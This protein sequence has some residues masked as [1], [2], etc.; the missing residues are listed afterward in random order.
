MST[1]PNSPRLIKGGLVLLEPNSGA[2]LRVI[3]LQYNPDTLT[4]TLQPQAVA[5]NGERARA[6]RLKGPPVETIKFDAEIDATDQLEFPA[7]NPDAAQVGI[8]PQLA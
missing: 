1:F 6:L 8:Q 3:T 4:R 7:E 5:E 2:V